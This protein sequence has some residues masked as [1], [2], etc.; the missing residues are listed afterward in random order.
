MTRHAYSCTQCFRPVKDP[1]FAGLSTA[2]VIAKCETLLCS[3]CEREKA[4]AAADA[5]CGGHEWLI[6]SRKPLV[7]RCAKCGREDSDAR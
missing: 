2:E 1:S 7:C 3:N 4:D 5:A 6:I